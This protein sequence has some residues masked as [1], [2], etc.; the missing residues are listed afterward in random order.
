[1]KRP[2]HWILFCIAA[3]AIAGCAYSRQHGMPA[4]SLKSPAAPAPVHG[5]VTDMGA[6]DAFIARRPTAD[7]FRTAYPDVLL[8]LPNMPTTMEMRYN[9]SRYFAEIDGDGRVSGGRFQ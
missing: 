6:F 2:G 8:I 7:E 1:M 5:F 3:A 4:P 9:N